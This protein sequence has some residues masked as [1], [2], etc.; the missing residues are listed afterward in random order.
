MTTSMMVTK[1]KLEQYLPNNNYYYHN[2]IGNNNK[3]QEEI[4]REDGDNDNIH[5]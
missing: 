2:T 3:I 1:T 4:A 5:K